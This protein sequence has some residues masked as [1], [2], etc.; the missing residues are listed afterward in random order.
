MHNIWED[1]NALGKGKKNWKCPRWL[2]RRV[3][4]KGWHLSRIQSALSR[5]SDRP[6]HTRVYRAFRG[7]EAHS[8][9]LFMCMSIVPSTVSAGSNSINVCWMHLALIIILYNIIFNILIPMIG[10]ILAP[11]RQGENKKPL[12]SLHTIYMTYILGLTWPS[13]IETQS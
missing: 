13:L 3:V 8:H 4:P 12:I 7:P 6:S 5:G 10:L 1:V 9:D 2:G 11:P